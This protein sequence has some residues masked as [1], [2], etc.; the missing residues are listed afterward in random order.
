MAGENI[1][2]TKFFRALLKEFDKLY[3]DNNFDEVFKLWRKFNITLGKKVTVLSAETG[4]IFTG[5]ALDID[6]DGAL[7]VETNGERKT[8]YAGDVSI[9]PAK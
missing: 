5:T 8:V 1:S 9:R 6:K 7:I 4:D 3:I 2:R